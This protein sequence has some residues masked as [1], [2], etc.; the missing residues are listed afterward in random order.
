ML[1]ICETLDRL[2]C[3]I[4]TCNPFIDLHEKLR[5]RATLYMMCL[6]KCSLAFCGASDSSRYVP[7]VDFP[8]PSPHTGTNCVAMQPCIPIP[9]LPA[10]D[11]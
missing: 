6:P 7:V 10:T 2:I 11:E 1:A 9:L 5:R 3:L 8:P 4:M